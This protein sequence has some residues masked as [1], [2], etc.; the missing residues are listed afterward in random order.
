MTSTG[1][2][3]NCPDRVSRPASARRV[4]CGQA[5]AQVV[6]AVTGVVP[7]A[8]GGAAVLRLVVPG[9]ATHDALGARG[10]G[11]GIGGVFIQPL[12]FQNAHQTGQGASA[13]RS[14]IGRP[15]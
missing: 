3:Q 4:S 1:S 5:E 15:R 7:V 11:K 12:Q 6:V 2:L 9:A 10:L 8:V 14:G 13:A